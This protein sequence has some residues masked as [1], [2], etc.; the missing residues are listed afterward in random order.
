[1]KNLYK[2]PLAL[3]FAL[4]VILYSIGVPVPYLGRNPCTRWLA[5]SVYVALPREMCYDLG[6]GGWVALP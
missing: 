3:A 5:A 1:M 2:N 4:L 6:G